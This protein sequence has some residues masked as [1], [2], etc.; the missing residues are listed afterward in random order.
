MCLV[1]VPAHGPPIR[2]LD[3]HLKYS[4]EMLNISW[5]T[6]AMSPFGAMT[7]IYCKPISI[8]LFNLIQPLTI[9]CA[10]LTA[11]PCATTRRFQSL[12]SL[13]ALALQQAPTRVTAYTTA[14][15]TSVQEPPSRPL[16]PLEATPCLGVA[17]Y[18]YLCR[19]S[20]SLEVWGRSPIPAWRKR[21]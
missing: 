7:R 18:L 12:P 5:W 14:S 19:A 15:R 11:F 8:Q 3:L 20:P 16:V 9:L 2:D 21:R 6:G 1:R 13:E 10:S 17:P 4:I